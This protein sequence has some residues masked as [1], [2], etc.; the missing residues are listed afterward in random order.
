MKIL[1]SKIK[2]LIT[3]LDKEK[4][5]SFVE[6]AIKLMQVKLDCEF[7]NEGFKFYNQ[8][9]NFDFIQTLD[10]ELDYLDTRNEL[11]VHL[12]RIMNQVFKYQLIDL[13]A[14]SDNDI[15]LKAVN[16]LLKLQKNN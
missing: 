16:N 14:S 3:D 8:I 7:E 11:D 1:E 4:M 15:K 5:F 13:K 10:Y 6:S 2:L 9:K 12:N